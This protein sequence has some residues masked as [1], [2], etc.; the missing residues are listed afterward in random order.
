MKAGFTILN[1]AGKPKGNPDWFKVVNVGSDTEPAEM[2]IYGFIGSDPFTESANDIVR[3]SEELKKIPRNREIEVKIHSQGG[4]V[5]EAL[6]IYDAFRTRRDKVTFN[7][8]GLAASCGSFIPMAG[9]KVKM[10]AAARWMHHDAHTFAIG[11]AAKFK[12]VQE[13]L[14]RESDNIAAIYSE[15]SGKA[16]AD[17]RSQ[18]KKTTWLTGQ[19]AKTE[20]F[21]DE[22]TNLVPVNCADLSF[23]GFSYEVPADLLTQPSAGSG[24][25]PPTPPKPKPQT[26][27][28]RQELILACTNLGIAVVD[29]DTDEQLKT[30]L[31]AFKPAPAKPPENADTAAGALLM[32]QVQNISA[33]LEREKKDRIERAIDQCLVDCRITAAEK[34]AVLN[35]ALKDETYLAEVQARP[36]MLPGGEPMNSITDVGSS[37][38]DLLTGF[39]NFS[40]PIKAWQKG[41]TVSASAL[42]DASK[43]RGVFHMENRAK[44]L[45]VMNTNTVPTELKRNFILQDKI[46]DFSRRLLPLSSF[47]TNFGNVPLEG[48][49]KVEV[50]YFDLDSSAATS[51]VTGTG[52][53]TT[54]DTTV[55]VR[56][57]QI[58]NNGG[59]AA[60]NCDRK[61]IGLSL[62]SEELRRQPYLSIMD[63]VGLK[64]DRLADRVLAHVLGIITV[65]NYGAAV[66]AEPPAAFDSNDLADL[67]L[68]CK[69]WPSGGRSLFLDSA[70]DANLLKDNAFKSALNAASDSAIKEGRLYPRVYGFDYIENPTIPDNS[71][72]L[73]GFA[74]F[75][76]AILFATAPVPPL[77]EVRAA[78]VSY[79]VFTHPLSGLSFEYRTFGD[80]VTDTASHFIEL[81][82]GF[83]KGNGNALKR[84][85][86]PAL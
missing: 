39:A 34:P 17:I 31:L 76:S 66:V 29:S 4:N 7:I 19:Q 9:K 15:K 55:G 36:Q 43:Q 74:L 26:L 45:P 37:T 65:A 20:G 82:Y 40:K 85:E 53:T 27:M 77:E 35:R 58:G 33:Q 80:A 78:G 61:F 8:V 63:T 28:N 49:N 79:E 30:K 3:I 38:K 5:W 44:L 69:L 64:I 51:F 54:T 83:A 59:N 81:N 73:A 72:K 57:I 12:E 46:F 84:I 14:D 50:R 48:T 62:S 1:T 70:Y 41:N 42:A 23:E 67:K 16:K 13:M 25:T 21:V 24:G 10:S 52:Y 56:E 32:Q 6:A 68:A 60:L 47:S 2:S 86:N 71:E 22:L 18:M 11:D 75:K